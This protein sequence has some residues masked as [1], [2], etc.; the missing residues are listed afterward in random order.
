MLL[1]LEAQELVVG[2]MS[3]I[4][5]IM[6]ES[7]VSIIEPLPETSNSPVPGSINPNPREQPPSIVPVSRSFT[8]G[9]LFPKHKVMF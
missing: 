9:K 4:L 6:V 2:S 8:G 3:F 5:Q 7:Q 1:E